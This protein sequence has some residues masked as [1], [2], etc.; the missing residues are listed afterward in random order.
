MVNHSAKS[1][2]KRYRWARNRWSKNGIHSQVAEG[3]QSVFKTAMHVYR[4]FR[5]QYSQLYADEWCLMKNLRYFG[6]DRI[7]GAGTGKVDCQDTDEAAVGS[8]GR[9]CLIIF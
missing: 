8:G 1:P 6:I 7:A 4:Y 2:E 9:E 3:N 5:P